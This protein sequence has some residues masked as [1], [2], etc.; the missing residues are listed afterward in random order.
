MIK[1]TGVNVIDEYDIAAK[2]MS[3]CF[4]DDNRPKNFDETQIINMLQQIKM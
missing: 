2:R 1:K 3:L 4:I